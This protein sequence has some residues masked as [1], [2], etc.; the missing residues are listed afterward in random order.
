[1]SSRLAIMEIDRAKRYK[2]KTNI[3]LKRSDQI[4]GW[5]ASLQAADFLEDEKT[6]LATY[7]AFQEIV[8]ACM[9]IVAMMCKDMNIVPKDDYTNIDNLLEIDKRTKASLYEANGLRNRLV[10]RYNQTDD[11]IAFKGIKILLPELVDFMEKVKIWIRNR[12]R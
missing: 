2:D 8:E 11:L 12:L 4:R 7:K 3:I 10:H 1:M 9:D 6:K 5:T